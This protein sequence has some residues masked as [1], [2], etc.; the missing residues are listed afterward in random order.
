MDKLTMSVLGAIAGVA[1]AGSAQAST[2]VDGGGANATAGVSSYAD[3][4]APIPNAAALLKAEDAAHSAA[5]HIELAQAYLQFQY[6]PPPPPPP[7]YYGYPGPYYQHHHHH[8][9]R[10]YRPQYHHHHHHHHHGYGRG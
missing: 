2:A 4:L 5:P 8:H 7:P 1:V 9:H 10:Y 3:L 6:G